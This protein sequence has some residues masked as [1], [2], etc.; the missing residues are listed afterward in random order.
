MI[1]D[2]FDE[3]LRPFLL[4]L[5][6]R[7]D[8]RFVSERPLRDV[9]IVE[10]RIALEQGLEIGMAVAVMGGEDIGDT[11]VESLHHAVGLR[12]ARRDQPML[13]GVR[14]AFLIEQ[15]MAR[16]C[17]PAVDRERHRCG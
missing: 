10:V 7:L 17:A 11:P 14:R 15:V 3:E 12:P 5:L 4:P 13:D 6:H 9:V 1:P 16:G 2:L 8:G